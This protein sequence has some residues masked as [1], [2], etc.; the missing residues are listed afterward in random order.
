[1]RKDTCV[2]HWVSNGEARYAFE[3][4]HLRELTVRVSTLI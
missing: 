3:L 4:E 2:Q 1:M